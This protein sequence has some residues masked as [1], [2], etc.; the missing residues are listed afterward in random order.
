MMPYLLVMS[1]TTTPVTKQ[2]L[3]SAAT[4]GTAFLIVDQASRADLMV[5]YR[6]LMGFA[7]KAAHSAKRM[8]LEIQWRL[9][10]FSSVFGTHW[11]GVGR[12]PETAEVLAQEARSALAS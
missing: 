12:L 10:G 8:R 11:Y 3:L 1:R 6:E 5:V 7:P 2:I 9:T 4:L